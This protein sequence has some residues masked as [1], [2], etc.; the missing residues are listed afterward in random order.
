MPRSVNKHVTHA[1]PTISNNVSFRNTVNAR[2]EWKPKIFSGI[3][4]SSLMKKKSSSVFPSRVHTDKPR[5]VEGETSTSKS[6]FNNHTSY[7]EK[8]IRRFNHVDPIPL[9]KRN[10]LKGKDM[11]LDQISHLSEEVKRLSLLAKNIHNALWK[12]PYYSY[13]KG[14]YFD[15]Y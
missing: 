11:S 9:L 13:G 1:R 10:P 6:S 4:D 5:F 12:P 2:F 7:F 15:P 3:V 14:E 8:G